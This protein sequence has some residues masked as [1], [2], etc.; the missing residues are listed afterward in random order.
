[1]EKL[2]LGIVQD[3]KV[4]LFI[5]LNAFV[6]CSCCGPFSCHISTLNSALVPLIAFYDRPQMV[7]TIKKN[8]NYIFKQTIAVQGF[9]I[10][11]EKMTAFVYEVC[12]SLL[13]CRQ[14]KLVRNAFMK[15][16]EPLF[17]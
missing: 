10:T 13:L 1:M 11:F 15:K 7:S 16:G 8:Y 12:N 17:L 5:L 3:N 4:N 14:Q 9:S 6:L 2:N